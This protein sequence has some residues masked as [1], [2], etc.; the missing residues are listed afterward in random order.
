MHFKLGEDSLGMMPGRVL[1]D[2]E[3]TSDGLIGSSL[4]QEA[5]NLRLASRQPKLFHQLVLL[6]RPVPTIGWPGPGLLLKVTSESSQ[7][8]NGPAKLF[9]QSAVVVPQGQEGG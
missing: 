8:V 7:F 3:L 5:G 4:T 6:L 1:A 9:D 2:I